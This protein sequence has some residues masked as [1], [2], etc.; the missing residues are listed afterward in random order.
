[1]SSKLLIYPPG[2]LS[3]PLKDGHLQASHYLRPEKLCRGAIAGHWLE[4]RKLK[5]QDDSYEIRRTL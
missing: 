3:V 4:K 1:M 5:S 2:D